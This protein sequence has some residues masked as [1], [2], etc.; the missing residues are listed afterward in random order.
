MPRQVA[1]LIPVPRGAHDVFGDSYALLMMEPV[2]SDRVPSATLLKSLFDL[3]PSEARVASGIA[4]GETPDSIAA[5]G[6]VAISTVRSQIRSV[7]EKTGTSR[8]SRSEEHTS[9]LQSLMRNSYAVYCL[10]KK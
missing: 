3:T 7:L 2:A 4:R 5:S 6:Q 1:H 10:K 8:Q 9:E